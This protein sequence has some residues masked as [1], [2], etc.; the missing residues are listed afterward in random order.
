MKKVKLVNNLAKIILQ[1]L[2]SIKLVVYEEN[3]LFMFLLGP[4][5]NYVLQGR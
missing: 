5:L 1:S 3:F 2:G 4:I